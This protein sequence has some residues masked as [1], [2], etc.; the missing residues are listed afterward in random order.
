[1]TEHNPNPNSQA[2][3]AELEALNFL[4]NTGVA[5]IKPKDQGKVESSS[6]ISTG[7]RSEVLKIEPDQTKK[8]S[9]S[10][11]N[12]MESTQEEYGEL[13]KVIIVQA[14]S[15]AIGR[16]K[17]GEIKSQTGAISKL[18]VDIDGY[19]EDQSYQ[20]FTDQMELQIQK[21]LQKN[22][23]SS[24]IINRLHQLFTAIAKLDEEKANKS[25][26]EYINDELKN[27]AAKIDAKK[28]EAT[29]VESAL[30]TARMK[31]RD[32]AQLQ[33]GIVDKL[34]G[35]N[36]RLHELQ[37]RSIKLNETRVKPG[38]STKPPQTQTP[39]QNKENTDSSGNSTV[40]LE[41]PEQVPT[42]SRAEQRRRQLDE[43]AAVTD[44]Q[45][46]VYIEA[47]TNS[48]IQAMLDQE[49]VEMAEIESV[50]Q[51][52]DKIIENYYSNCDAIINRETDIQKIDEFLSQLSIFD[53][54]NSLVSPE[55]FELLQNFE[56]QSELEKHTIIG[57]LIKDCTQRRVELALKLADESNG[58]S[59]NNLENNIQ[60]K[61]IVGI[62]FAPCFAI[63]NTF[64]K[65]LKDHNLNR[66]QL[67]KL[68]GLVNKIN[69][70][71]I[72]FIS[73]YNP[74]DNFY[75]SFVLRHVGEYIPESDSG[76]LSDEL[77]FNDSSELDVSDFN[78]VNYFNKGKFKSEKASVNGVIV[79]ATYNINSIKPA[80]RVYLK[81][82]DDNKIE[83]LALDSSFS[84]L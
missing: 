32:L 30:R 5:N 71:Y 25:E 13:R 78:D 39:I 75:D 1:M 34:E 69:D 12:L 60:Y 36:V 29:E 37:L 23:S 77:G 40:I 43:I 44:A 4:L 83:L 19:N 38:A 46:Q 56:F 15:R 41:Q 61:E 28:E 80:K 21:S 35:E 49:A 53:I 82:T 59:S 9:T 72:E 26:K 58:K 76:E 20:N 52:R 8:H 14:I 22:E 65:M 79:D 48:S 16:F 11:R 62:K 17:L 70:F 73:K 55:G 68:Q 31:V 63:T 51:A 84:H 67:A 74:S 47:K 33:K 3:Q 27:Q 54:D 57:E 18:L 6:P 2:I 10:Y 42:L 64:T 24:V 7:S 45:K 50:K 66:V 81:K